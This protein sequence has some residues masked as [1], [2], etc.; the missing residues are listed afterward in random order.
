MKAFAV[1]VPT[2]GARRRRHAVRQVPDPRRA[3][4]HPREAR[5]LRR[6]PAALP[7]DAHRLAAFSLGQGRR[8]PR[9]C[10]RRPQS[11][12]LGFD[13]VNSNTFQDQ[14]GQPLATSSARST[15]T[16]KAVRDQ[17]IAHNIDC[18]EIGV[19]LGSKAI[20]VWIGDGANFP[21][22]QDLTGAFDR[23][24]DSMRAI[25][26]ALPADWRHVHGAQALRAGLLFD[27]D[28]ATG[29]RNLIAAQQLG[30]KAQC[31]VDLGHHAPN[32]NIEQIVARLARFGKLG[33]FHF[34][35]SQVRRRRPRSPARSIRTSCSWSSTSWSRPSRARGGFEPA[36]MIDQSHNVTDP[37]ESLLSSAE[38]IAGAYARALVVDREALDEAQEANDVMMAF[39]TPAAPTHRRARRSS[40]CRVTAA[41]GAIDPIAAYRA[42]RLSA[43]QGA[44]ATCASRRGTGDR[45]MHSS[46]ARQADSRV[47]GERGFISFQALERSRATRRRRPSGATSSGSRW[48]ADH[49]VHGGAR[50]SPR[51]GRER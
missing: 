42:E 51:C 30:D 6:G 32:V 45:L 48:P 10:A 3:D 49:R 38:A 19:A 9:P 20:T 43:A 16:D 28:L 33:G 50:R 15:H 25:Y 21:G 35:D 24:L 17:A 44:G 27:R 46:G 29:A 23:Y 11:L 4:R 26:A 41:G 39:Q 12:G 2:W 7:H 36:Y 34:N 8:L 1:A 31:L 5:G 18:I 13:A 22:Q 14:P 47:P 40:P 37:I